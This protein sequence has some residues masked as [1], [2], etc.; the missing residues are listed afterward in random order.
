MAR[1]DTKTRQAE[2]VAAAIAIIGEMGV[3]GLTTA[4]LAGRLGMSE[5]NLYRHFADKQAILGAVVDEIGSSIAGKAA[6]IAEQD[7][8]AD[9]KL[10]KILESHV[11]EV[12]Q[13][14]GIPRLVFSEEVHVSNDELRVRLVGTISVYLA[15][16]ESVVA[17]GI[18]SGTLRS[19]IRAPETAR[20]FLGMV[21]FSA[22]R[23]SLSGFGFDLGREAESLWG[24]FY[25]MVRP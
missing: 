10:R 8:P 15:V 19:G 25:E 1:K 16:I 6:A 11:R 2:I 12:E 14:S 21:Q 20:T 9:V 23:W 7:M 17:D 5:P 18:E 22:L 4:R 13:K 24:N 3:R